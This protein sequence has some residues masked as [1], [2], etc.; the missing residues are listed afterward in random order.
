LNADNELVS[1][2]PREATAARKAEMA[3][4]ERSEVFVFAAI[5]L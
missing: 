1:A 5:L 2:S 3:H 4:R